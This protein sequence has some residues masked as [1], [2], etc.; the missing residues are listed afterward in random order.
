MLMLDAPG[1]AAGFVQALLAPA[2]FL[3]LIGLGLLAGRGSS[4]AATVVA[5][6]FGLAGGLGAIA[7]GAGET[8]A[9]EVLF[10]AS[11]VCGAVAALGRPAATW[12]AA[13]AALVIGCALGLDSPPDAISLREAVWTL[14]GT[15]FGAVAALALMAA[16]AARVRQAGWAIALRVAGSW[17]AAIAVLVLALRWRG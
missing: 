17:L 3:S 16:S 15:G 10:A 8:P 5:F 9:S 13:P 12:L 1:L 6:T 11:G 2:H 14:I 7:W 4:Q